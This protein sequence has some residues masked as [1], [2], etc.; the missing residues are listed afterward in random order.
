[1]CTVRPLAVCGAL[2]RDQVPCLAAIARGAQLDAGEAL[3]YE[4]DPA[5]EVFTVTRGMLKLSKLL[6][7]GRRQIT[8]FLTPGDYLG[9]AFA[10]RYVYSAE[11]VTPVRICRFPRSA[12]LGLLEQFPALEKALFG[13]AATELAAAQQ[14]MLLLGCKTARE[15]V[16]SFLLQLA[17]RQ[18]AEEGAVV[19]LP[20]T[21]TDIA[22]YLG[23]TIETV[24]RTLSSLR[25]AGL[26]ALPDLHHLR[27]VHRSRLGTE[28]GG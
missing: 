25:K 14:Q 28:S 3:F 13:R 19:D 5:T 27:I 17:E 2:T 7:D 12:F 6:P 24:S 18:G 21:R 1:V 20:M 23:V 8:G 10:E 11:A 15:R 22:D 9:L 4:D 16:A 26:I